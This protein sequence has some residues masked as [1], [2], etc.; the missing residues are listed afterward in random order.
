MAKRLPLTDKDGEVRELTK[1]DFKH[2]KPAAEVLSKEL[3]KD[4]PRR[5]RPVSDSPKKPVQILS[6]RRSFRHSR[7]L[8]AAGRPASTKPSATG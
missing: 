4:L 3:V 8:V 6:R 5:G 7:P 1:D 2:F